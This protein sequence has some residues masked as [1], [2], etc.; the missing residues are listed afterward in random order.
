MKVRY[1]IVAAATL[2]ASLATGVPTSGRAEAATIAQ[3]DSLAPASAADLVGIDLLA[4]GS[5]KAL[6][7][8]LTALERPKLKPSESY[9]LYVAGR[10]SG[11]RTP[12]PQNLRIGEHRVSPVPL[13]GAIV[14]FGSTI[15]GLIAIGRQKRASR[16]GTA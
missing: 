9:A 7:F 15:V 13:P 14:L 3:W 16:N 5:G 10:I 11:A 8:D 4:G 2:C 12:Y 1:C 6:R